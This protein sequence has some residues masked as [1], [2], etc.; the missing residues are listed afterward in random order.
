MVATAS[1]VISPPGP[2]ADGQRR[3]RLRLLL[4]QRWVAIAGQLL[5]VLVVSFALG[6]QLEWV[7]I[8]SLIG[9][10][11][12]LNMSAFLRLGR[13]PWLKDRAAFS[14]ILYDTIQLTLLLILTGGILNPFSILMLA[15]VTVGAAI[16]SRRYTIWITAVAVVG[17]SVM[18]VFH[19]PLPWPDG[20]ALQLDRLHEFGIWFALV[21]SCLFMATYVFGV[22][23]ESR[24]LSEALAHT[25]TALNREQKAS[26]LGALA[27][28]AAHELGSPLGTI[29]VVVG[30][31]LKD[32]P[33][34][35]MLRDDL[36]LMHE[37]VHRCRE[38]LTELS[39]SQKSDASD[40]PFRYMRL[41]PL[42]DAIAAPSRNDT[43]SF[44]VV[45][46]RG[47]RED[48]P[49]GERSPEFV[50]GLT[51]IINNAISFARTRVVAE[52]GWDDAHVVIRIR[53]DGPGFPPAQLTRLGEPFRSSRAGN[54][55]HMGLGLFIAQTLL[56][57]T[58]ASIR[59]FNAR[60]GG[61][62]V[63]MTWLRGS[64]DKSSLVGATPLAEPPCGAAPNPAW[65]TCGPSNITRQSAS[66]DGANDA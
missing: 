36:T 3:V 42:V 64:F 6:I 32:H 35:G 30:D 11:A 45:R 48:M 23:E 65:S 50:H 29:A 31:L 25:Q 37:Q 41:M 24:R 40:D 51:N 59:L 26:A 21:L 34:E 39:R 10:S 52:C 46:V 1:H 16:L 56:G 47:D 62:V 12:T 19:Q 55:G 7:P 60:A 5:T 28:S 27:A 61:A 8:L 49:V 58:G 15:P 20:T 44:E 18:W 53:D 2:E 63:E 66:P 38:I 57:H 9:L 13:E 43:I 22:A 54:E 4:M 33:E 17:L 14:F